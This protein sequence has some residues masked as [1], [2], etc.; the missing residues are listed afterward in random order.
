M[1]KNKI[2]QLEKKILSGPFKEAQ[3]LVNSGMAWK[4][5]GSVGRSCME[6]IN[7]GAVLLGEKGHLDYYGN[8]VPSRHEVKAGTKGSPEFVMENHDDCVFHFENQ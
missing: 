3:E 2:K 6:A 4:L 1:D 8:Y 7:S 5:E